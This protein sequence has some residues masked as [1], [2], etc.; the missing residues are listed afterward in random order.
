MSTGTSTASSRREQYLRSL[1]AD[2]R[3]PTDSGKDLVDE[4]GQLVFVTVRLD[5]LSPAVGGVCYATISGLDDTGKA[6]MVLDA[7][8]HAAA[9]EWMSRGS[10]DLIGQ[11]TTLFGQPGLDLRRVNG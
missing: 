11:A 6:V 1:D 2:G 3:I 4:I 7:E 8:D 10:A 5:S 9:L